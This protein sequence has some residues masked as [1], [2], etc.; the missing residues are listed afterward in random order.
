MNK[1]NWKGYTAANRNE[2]IE[3]IKGIVNDHHGSIMNF[4]MFSDLG[5]NLSIEIA[6]QDIVGFHESLSKS[7]TVS[8]LESDGINQN[9]TK[10]WLIFL[11]ISFGQGTG[12]LK[13]EIPE[14][15]G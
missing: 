15:P 4:N 6:E 1:L 3:A 7:I 12:E 2:S 10:D 8:S 14:V 9:S 11:N 5:I 13:I